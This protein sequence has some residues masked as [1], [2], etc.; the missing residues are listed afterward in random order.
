[1][2]KERQPI[3]V[4]NHKTMFEKQPI[5]QSEEQENKEREFTKLKSDALYELK[6]GNLI[7]FFDLE[8]A[9]PEG[10]LTKEEIIEMAKDSIK[11]Y[12]SRKNRD[13]SYVFDIKELF[14]IPD[15]FIHSLEVIEIIKK[16]LIEALS[17][18]FIDYVLWIKDKFNITDDPSKEELISAHYGVNEC[19]KIK[20]FDQAIKIAKIYNLDINDIYQR[21]VIRNSQYHTDS[22]IED[23]LKKFNDQIKLSEEAPSIIES[24]DG[25]Y[26]GIFVDKVVREKFKNI[27]KKLVEGVDQKKIQQLIFL[28]TSA[29]FF[30]NFF[31]KSWRILHPDKKSPDVSFVRISSSNREVNSQEIIEEIK[32]VFGQKFVD[33]TIAIIDEFGWSGRTLKKALKVFN[34]FSDR[35]KIYG[36]WLS[37][38]GLDYHGSIY[39]DECVY[40]HNFNDV[41]CDHPQLKFTQLIGVYGDENL[42]NKGPLTYIPSGVLR[43]DDPNSILSR[44]WTKTDLPKHV[45]EWYRRKMTTIRN[46]FNMMADELKND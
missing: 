38:D 3:N 39:F 28:D 18:G 21:W 1:M 42:L 9:L 34:H 27:I 6:Q 29:R 32:E 33:Q 16:K 36:E 20:C 31:I 45:E 23:N 12:L 37:S 15:E 5:P 7:K 4:N 19:L 46:Q 11:E 24:I 17:C 40:G 8:A 30:G 22:I 35:S 43:P 13:V 41:R 44:S 10:L 26:D 25:G 2:F 14:D